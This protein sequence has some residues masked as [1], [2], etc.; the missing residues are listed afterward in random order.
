MDTEFQTRFWKTAK[1]RIFHFAGNYTF[2]LFLETQG[3]GKFI[4]G[5]FSKKYKSK[6]PS[7]TKNQIWNQR[8]KLNTSF[9]SIFDHSWHRGRWAMFFCCPRN[10]PMFL[11]LIFCHFWNTQIV[12]ARFLSCSV[13][14]TFEKR[15][16]FFILWTEDFCKKIKIK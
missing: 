11:W 6:I 3:W 13:L 4:F 8:T 9:F 2:W 5:V 1:L 10:L 16:I 12:G 14:Q 15:I 7:W